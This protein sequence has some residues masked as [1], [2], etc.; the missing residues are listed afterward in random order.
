M[1]EGFI[2]YGERVK[3]DGK[4]KAILECLE[5]NARLSVAMIARKTGIQ[6]DSVL[7]RMKRLI[8]LK[9][10]R[11]FHTVLNPPILGY[12]V[13]VFVNLELH[14]LS[15]EAEKGLLAFLTAHR[16]IVYCA[17]TTG[18]WDLTLVIAARDLKNFDEIIHEIRMKFPK[19]LKDYESASIIQEY[20][21]DAMAGLID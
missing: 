19:I 21:Y 3:L 15:T 13:Y 5:R 2:G 14:N 9:V 12:P 7:Y 10:I 17:K 16:N 11:S 6:R 4:D 8:A 18:K 1:K 20:K